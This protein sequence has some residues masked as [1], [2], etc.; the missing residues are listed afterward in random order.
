MNARLSVLMVCGALV[1]FW[2]VLFFRGGARQAVGARRGGRVPIKPSRQGLGAN[3]LEFRVVPGTPKAYKSRQSSDH[4]PAGHAGLSAGFPISYKGES[5]Y[6]RKI[7][8]CSGKKP[9]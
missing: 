6:K 2:G 8:N 7:L 4:T 3:K 1:S 9:G 5:P